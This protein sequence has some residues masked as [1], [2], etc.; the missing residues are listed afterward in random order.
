MTPSEMYASLLARDEPIII[1]A[2]LRAVPK[3]RPRFAGTHTY[4]P[5]ATKEFELQIR[6]LGK[7]AM[8]GKRPYNCP[9]AVTVTIVE[10]VPQS[11]TAIEKEAA[12]AGYTVPLRGDLDNRV[13][14]ITD[15]LNGVVYHDDVQ[16]G[17]TTAVKKY[18]T[19]NIITVEIKRC[20]L[21]DIEI[22]RVKKLQKVKHG[23][24]NSDSGPTVG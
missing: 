8:V 6:T 1:R 4:T 2:G 16:I 18:G 14:A 17:Q 23:S 3:G 7:S 5:K 21:S 11:R 22:D 9:V 24:R 13:K 15:A 12:L 19:L 10:E 20:G